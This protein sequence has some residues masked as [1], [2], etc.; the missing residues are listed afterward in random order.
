MLQSLLLPLLSGVAAGLAAALVFIL[1]YTRNQRR[2]AT[3]I[4][5][6]ARAEA[7]RLRTEGLREAESAKADLLVT[8]KMET[9]K[10]REELDREIQ[11]RREE[12]E[13]LERRADERSRAQE[14]K[15]EEL[16]S[17]ERNAMHREEELN[18]R[19]Q[20]LRSREGEADRLAQEQRLKLERI[21]GLT[22]EDAR[23]E[24]L[25]RVED[26][27]RGQAAA[28]VREI[29]EQAR[30]G[31]DREARRIISIAVQRLAAE[32]TAESTVAAVALPSDEMKGRIIGREGRNIRAFE[33]ATGVDVIID[34]TPD[35]VTLSCF[36]P[37]RRE[38]ARLALEQLIAD[39]RIHPGR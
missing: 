33:T 10:L 18:Q 24:I 9:L 7:Q 38:V 28:L 37:V 25:Q 39:G 16:E 29:K 12:W 4:L 13:R 15:L 11:R 30:R 2:S 14:R 20:N 6:V 34:D 21:A 26:E 32:H 3:G 19:Q 22:A 31:A 1:V 27:A 8:A 23:R 17:R 5:S 35:A 36:D